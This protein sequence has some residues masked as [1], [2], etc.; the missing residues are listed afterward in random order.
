MSWPAT[1]PDCGQGQ[2]LDLLAQQPAACPVPHGQ[3]HERGRQERDGH[4]RQPVQRADQ[5]CPPDRPGMWQASGFGK[6]SET[7]PG[8]GRATSRGWMTSPAAVSP[9]SA[10]RPRPAAASAATAAS[11]SGTAGT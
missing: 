11:R 1:N 2:P 3:G 7:P 4:H 8:A 5:D 10:S 9:A 6:V